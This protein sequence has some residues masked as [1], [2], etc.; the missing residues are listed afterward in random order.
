MSLSCDK[1]VYYPNENFQ[2]TQEESNLGASLQNSFVSENLAKQIASSFSKS[3]LLNEGEILGK[4]TEINREVSEVIVVPDELGDPALYILKYVGSGYMILSATTKESPVLGFS[5]VD[6]F[7]LENI[8]LGLSEWFYD[9]MHKI[10]IINHN[11]NY[12][13]PDAVTA[14]WSAILNN[15]S[16]TS[17]RTGND[18]I[19]SKMYSHV[20]T[21]DIEKYGEL[22]DTNWDQRYP[23]NM[24]LTT[25][26]CGIDGVA[27]GCVAIAFGQVAKYHAKGDYN[28]SLMPSVTNNIPTQLGKQEVARLCKDIGS[29]VNMQYGCYSSG[30]QTRDGI[31]FL[32][33]KLGYSSGGNYEL[34][35]IDQAKPKIIADIKA[36]RPVI[37]DGYNTYYTYTK[38]WWFWKKTYEVYDDGHTWV[39]D[40]YKIQKTMWFA[41]SNIVRSYSSDFF[42]MNWGWGNIGMSSHDNN[43]WFKLDDIEIKDPNPNHTSDNYQHRRRYLTGINP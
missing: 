42:H 30:T 18:N 4:S 3:K 34:L 26:N 41:G 25:H 2:S 35:S 8:P 17:Q 38:G 20:V 5:N 33:N 24:N 22:L 10:Q 7:D 15:K 32:K 9:R 39:C 31:S 43:G 11:D 16:N 19:D 36:N 37:M 23:F 6:N 12:K 27:V 13:T 14:E 1:D 40:G 29:W 21:V 28:W